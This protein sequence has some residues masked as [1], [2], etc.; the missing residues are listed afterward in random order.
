MTKSNLGR[1][2]FVSLYR[3]YIHQCQSL[4][5][6]GRNSR[7]PGGRDWSRGHGGALTT[8]LALLTYS[9][10]FLYNS[11]CPEVQPPTIVWTFPSKLLIEKMHSRLAHRQILWVDFLRQESLFPDVSSLRQ[12]DAKL[13]NTVTFKRGFCISLGRGQETDAGPECSTTTWTDFRVFFPWQGAIWVAL[14]LPRWFIFYISAPRE[15]CSF[16]GI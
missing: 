5:E 1:K 15:D 16:L 3:L 12:A 6:A 7:F 2:R 11:A 4:S 13:S 9:A 14:S 10:F 8:G